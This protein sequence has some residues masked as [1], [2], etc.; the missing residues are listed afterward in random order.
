MLCPD[1]LSLSAFSDGGFEAARAA[2][3][4][5]HVA[6]C[7]ACRAFV[8]E[9][10]QL[11]AWGR[12]SLR[13]IKVTAEPALPV[14]PLIPPRLRLV[15][16]VALAAAAVFVAG[17]LVVLWL[18]AHTRQATRAVPV[19]GR[20]AEM[21]ATEDRRGSASDDETFARWAAPYRQLH[22]PLVPIEE[23]A[24]YS[25]PQIRPALPDMAAP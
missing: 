10:H 23:A 6:T 3:I 13:A 20:V 19:P 1:Q 22:I 9:L 16:P 14:V 12:S 21:A 2:E 11:E 18:G 4:A 7:A 5:D 25:P 8:D 15:R 17:V 24:R